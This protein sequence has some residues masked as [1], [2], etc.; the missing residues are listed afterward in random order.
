MYV[1]AVAF[2]TR[3][4]DAIFR[5]PWRWRKR[6]RPRARLLAS[7]AIAIEDRLWVR[8][9][10]DLGKNNKDTLSWHYQCVRRI[11][12]SA[13]DFV[14]RSSAP[15]SFGVLF[16][17]SPTEPP[18]SNGHDRGQPVRDYQHPGASRSHARETGETSLETD[19]RGALR[20]RGTAFRTVSHDSKQPR[21]SLSLSLCYLC[22]SFSSITLHSLTPP[23]RLSLS[24]RN[25]T[26]LGRFRPAATPVTS[27]GWA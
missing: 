14:L 23:S 17:W 16:V 25:L 18:G 6:A 2:I 7:T 12:K 1:A 19:P 13:W 3:D 10:N 24:P 5:A 11:L 21:F 4:S 27:R 15:G 26:R 22:L 9:K 8:K 20:G